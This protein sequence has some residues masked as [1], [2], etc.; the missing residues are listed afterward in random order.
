MQGQINLTERER[1]V[2]LLLIKID[3][4]WKPTFKEDYKHILSTDN[5]RKI[6]R[7]GGINK[8]NLSVY[9]NILK[10]KGCL[11]VNPRGGVEINPLLV[12]K[13]VGNIVEYTFT[14]E[15]ED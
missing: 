12:P 5:R 1:Q 2:L 15:I 11:V 8:N 3:Q 13:I 9:A 6:M 7:E 14:L 4:D 10:R